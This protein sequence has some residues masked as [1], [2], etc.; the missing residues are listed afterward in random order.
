[1]AGQGTPVGVGHWS[2]WGALS[3]GD[4]VGVDAPSDADTEDGGRLSQ[5]VVHLAQQPVKVVEGEHGADARHE[6]H[7]DT[8]PVQV[9]VGAAQDVSLDGAFLAVELG[10]C[11]HGD[12]GGQELG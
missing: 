7:G 11:A 4:G 1:M 9:Q 3:G 6:G 5:V 8:F 2:P 10:V 12:G